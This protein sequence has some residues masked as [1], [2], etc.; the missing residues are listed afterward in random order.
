MTQEQI[1]AAIAAAIGPERVKD[2]G[3]ELQARS[4][5]EIRDGL[6]LAHELEDPD[7]VQ[8][9]IVLEPVPVKL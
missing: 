4:V 2:L 5:A 9:S 8:Y 3:K 6:A 1:T 7:S